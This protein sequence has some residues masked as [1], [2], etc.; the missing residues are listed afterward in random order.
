L[1]LERDD[2]I[3]RRRAGGSAATLPLEANLGTGV[4]P[5]RDGDHHLFPVAH[6]PRTTALGAALGRNLSTAEAH[7]ARP[8]YGEPALAERDHAAAVAF[9]AHFQCRAGRSTGPVADVAL[10]VHL[11]L[12]R[13]LVARRGNAERNLEHRFDGLSPLLFTLPRPG[14]PFRAAAEHRREQ[15]TKAADTANVEVLEAELLLAA[16]ASASAWARRA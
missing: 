10:L 7:G 14:S 9:R 3:A 4:R 2:E 11:E 6:F 8:V 12:D 1:H 16:R 15:V 13:D 5:G